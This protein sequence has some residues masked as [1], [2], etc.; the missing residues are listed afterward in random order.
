MV[1][2]IHSTRGRPCLALTGL[3]LLAYLVP[4]TQELIQAWEH[5]PMQGY[6]SSPQLIVLFKFKTDKAMFCYQKKNH[7]GNEATTGEL[8]MSN[9][10]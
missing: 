5:D 9:R 4:Q 7:L 2:S 3:N 8:A 10:S 1:S 6:D